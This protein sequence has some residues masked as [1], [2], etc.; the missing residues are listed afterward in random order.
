MKCNLCNKESRLQNIAIVGPICGPCIAILE[1]DV[2]FD[3]VISCG[4]MR[5]LLE[6]VQVE[7]EHRSERLRSKARQI[8]ESKGE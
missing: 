7:F 1:R 3:G 4:S 2:L 5:F 8:V 6:A